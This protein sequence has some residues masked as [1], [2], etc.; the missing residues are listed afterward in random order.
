MDGNAYDKLEFVQRLSNIKHR[1]DY[2]ANFLPK[3]YEVTDSL[4]QY[5]K[6]SQ[7]K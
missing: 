4:F 7:N 1:A 5:T 3:T 2:I 6:I